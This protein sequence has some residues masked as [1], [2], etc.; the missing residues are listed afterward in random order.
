MTTPQK[1]EETAPF[2]FTW[3]HREE[4][5]V[6]L[7]LI[8]LVAFF[9]RSLLLTALLLVLVVGATGGLYLARVGGRYLHRLESL[10]FLV[11]QYHAFKLYLGRESLHRSR[12]A[13]A[14]LAA[15]VI[16]I[17]AVHRVLLAK[18]NPYYATPTDLYWM[19]F[20]FWYFLVCSAIA[21]YLLWIWGR[22]WK[23]P[24]M[25]FPF[26][27]GLVASL[28]FYHG[29]SR[30]HRIVTSI[31]AF[32]LGGVPSYFGIRLLADDPLGYQKAIGLIIPVIALTLGGAYYAMRCTE[33]RDNSL[34]AP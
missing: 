8:A 1:S 32:L 12:V 5:Q 17:L 13:M 27:D 24:Q 20:L 10:R 7:V 30:N 6:L 19:L 2:V 26:L 16:G 11:V 4:L 15:V 21:L 18:G 25:R 9:S 14:I 33:F 3:Y 22:V 23:T 31:A 34:D 28:F 29:L